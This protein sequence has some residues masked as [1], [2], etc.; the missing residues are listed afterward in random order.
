[1][2]LA[3]FLAIVGIMAA[4]AQEVRRALP[5]ER[6]GDN[7]LARFLAGLPLPEDAELAEWQYT[8]E[9]QEH[10]AALGRMWAHYYRHYFSPM[11]IWS[12]AELAPRLDMSRPVLYFF[13]GPD[14]ISPLALYPGA[15]VYALGG[16]EPIGSI[17]PPQDLTDE[18]M[19]GALAGLR[20]SMEVV[21]SYGHFITKDMKTDLERPAF[22]GVL[23]VL[24]AFLALSGHE[25]V[26]ASYFGVAADGHMT[27]Y[28][29]AYRES[30][31]HL[32]GVKVVFRV[33]PGRP[34]QTIYYVQANVANDAAPRNGSLKWAGNLG[35]GNVYLKA[36]SYLLQEPSF[37]H[38]RQFL[39]QS[40]ASVL[41]DDSGFPFSAFRDGQWRCYF[42][43]TYS[44][45]LEIFTK[46]FQPELQAAF[47]GP[48]SP[49]PF[50]TGYK[51]R[52]GESNLLLAIREAP[53][54]AVPVVP[55]PPGSEALPAG[56]REESP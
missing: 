32:P 36:A 4:S 28:G 24:F 39:L 2:R 55:L 8:P 20:E 22:R 16:L 49:L 30:K 38:V 27:E 18:Q 31:N 7:E 12:A 9:Y 17:A 19:A 23:P 41:Q 3:V 5:V 26:S 15:P 37:S 21:L 35:T 56:V 52:L 1:M 11:Q 47:A 25:V 34:L 6:T 33:G 42:F 54:K 50:G 45:T 29:T 53:P 43:G 13:G 44:G 40:G 51:W 48:S 46:Y 10:A 14:A